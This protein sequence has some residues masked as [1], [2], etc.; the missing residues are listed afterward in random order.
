MPSALGMTVDEIVAYL[1][2]TRLPTLVVEGV[3]DE[4][5]FRRMERAISNGVV[6]IFPVG[7][8]HTLHA[9]YDRRGEL[10]DCNVVFLRDRDEFIA[11]NTPVGFDDYVLTRG[12]S[13]EN[14]L[15]N[16]PVLE[17]LAGGSSGELTEIVSLVAEWFRFALSAFI[18]GQPNTLSRD[19]TAIIQ[20][21]GYTDDAVAEMLGVPHASCVALSAGDAW[22]WLRGKTLLRAVH[23]FF[24]GAALGYTKAQLIDIS[25][26]LGPSPAFAS[27]T[28][29]IRARLSVDTVGA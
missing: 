27:L 2:H 21:A 24:S 26:N 19:V 29:E 13:I 25:L 3:G 4:A 18:S 8:K 17:R 7:G 5:M 20:D 6:D 28:E 12:Y 1:G 15:L 10:A 11:I 22:T 9:I 14:D 23:H 16:R